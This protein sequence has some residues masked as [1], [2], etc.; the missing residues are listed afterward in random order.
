MGE[1]GRLLFSSMG[2]T[3][4]SIS[5]PHIEIEGAFQKRC[6]ASPSLAGCF[7]SHSSHKPVFRPG[8]RV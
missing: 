6:P 5:R 1:M 2:V 8:S 4:P 3:P 7:L